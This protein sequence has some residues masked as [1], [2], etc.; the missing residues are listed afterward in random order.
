MLVEEYVSQVLE[1]RQFKK[2]QNLHKVLGNLTMVLVGLLYPKHAQYHL[3]ICTKFSLS[4]TWV[5]GK[6]SAISTYS[7]TST[8]SATSTIS[9][10]PSTSAFAQSSH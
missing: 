7:T 10:T 8:I 5:V 3:D 2:N 9:S 4:V 6:F 1:K